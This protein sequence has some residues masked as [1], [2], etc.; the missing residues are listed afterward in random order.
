MSNEAKDQAPAKKKGMGLMTKGLIALALIGAGGGGAYALQQAGFLPGGGG[1]A[2]EVDPNPQLILKGETDPYYTASE[3]DKE[4]AL[5][6]PGDGGSKYRTAYFVF[7]DD[8]TS[9][10][11]GSTGLVQLS[12]AAAT[13]YDGRVLMWLKKHELAIRS[14]IV[15]ELADTPEE[16]LLTPEGKERLQKRLVDAI[17]E[18]LTE[19]EGFG[20]IK[21]VY[22]RSLLVQ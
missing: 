8:F 9:N 3:E 22:F 17:N 16:I 1:H 10:L 7:S 14:R 11:R 12:L 5:S 21:A 4:T 6:V 13:Q 19:A 2:E 15:V 18:E 20:G